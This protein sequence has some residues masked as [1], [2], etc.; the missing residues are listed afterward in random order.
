MRI[1]TPPSDSGVPVSST[2][3]R[4]V[5]PPLSVPTRL[6]VTSPSGWGALRCSVPSAVASNPAA[7]NEPA[8]PAPDVA[9]LAGGLA[10]AVA[11]LDAANALVG[12]PALRAQPSARGPDTSQTRSSTGANTTA[13]SPSARAPGRDTSPTLTR[14]AAAAST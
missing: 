11:V 14:H 10:D 5:A 13:P 4:L 12:V 7:G 9:G 3:I 1:S 8:P 6:M 2:S